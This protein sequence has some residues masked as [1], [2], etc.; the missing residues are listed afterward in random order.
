M[1]NAWTEKYCI[2]RN[3][4]LSREREREEIIKENCL[5]RIVRLCSTILYF[6]FYFS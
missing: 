1:T 6:T 4:K 3:E 5:A 2:E